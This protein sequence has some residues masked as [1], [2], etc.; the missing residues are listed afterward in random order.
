MNKNVFNIMFAVIAGLLALAVVIQCIRLNAAK[1][2]LS[3]YRAKSE[4]LEIAL[5]DSEAE[6][7]RLRELIVRANNALEEGLKR[8]EEAKRQYDE[9]N[10]KID[11]APADWL[12]CPLPDEVRD[13]F[14][15]YCYAGGEAADDSAGAM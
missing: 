5:R 4:G 15:A 10:E 7:Q 13:A 14:G 8:I 3:E 11:D 2:E 12:Q 6:N 1:K 9:R